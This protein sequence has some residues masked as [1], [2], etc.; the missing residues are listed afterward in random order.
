MSCITSNMTTA[1][2]DLATYDEMEKYMYGGSFAIAYFARET[3]KSTWFTQVPVV[4]SRSSG[5]TTF[6]N[7]WSVN[8]SR[9]G[10]YLLGNWLTLTIPETQLK[11]STGDKGGYSNVSTFIQWTPNLMHN[12]IA[13]CYISF[14][15]LVAAQ[16]NNFHLDF[17]ASFTVPACKSKGYNDMIGNTCHM[18]QPVPLQ[19]GNSLPGGTFHLPLPFFYTRDSG[20]ALPTAA[21]PYNDMKINFSFREWSELVNVWTVQYNNINQFDS[22]HKTTIAQKCESENLHDLFEGHEPTITNCGV[23]ANYAIVSNDERKKMAC[24]PRD[25]LIEQVQW[26]TP[27]KVT[28]GFNTNTPFPKGS[29]TTNQVSIRYAHAIKVLFFAIRNSTY[30]NYLSNY[31]TR[32]PMWG[33][34]NNDGETD[35]GLTFPGEASVLGIGPN[36]VSSM[37]KDCW[38]IPLNA[39]TADP[40][41]DLTLTYESTHRLSQLRSGYYSMVNPYFNAPRVP[42]S[43]VSAGQTVSLGRVLAKNDSESQCAKGQNGP[44]VLPASSCDAAACVSQDYAS[45]RINMNYSDMISGM[46]WGNYPT[47]VH[48]YSYSLDFNCLDPMGSTNYG[49]LTNIVV[50][51]SI[52]NDAAWYGATS[53]PVTTLYVPS[54]AD[55]NGDRQYIENLVTTEKN[56]YDFLITAVNNNIIRISGGALGFPV[57]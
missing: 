10:D 51:Y 34:F 32:T 22:Y 31:N 23:W 2:V 43:E 39:E 4:L 52:S 16:F 15:D 37:D 12:L 46:A 55:S 30:P 29:G 45:G 6:G 21:L 57:L 36:Y 7:D 9:A 38:G 14:N 35:V 11:T 17:W 44:S 3:R 54:P 25:M 48:S 50:N 24:A 5:E 28:N 41:F 33:V 26:N 56:N 13:D 19:K 1:F 40:L 18:L 8:I 49:K 42:L 53:K 47:G 20:V 27:N